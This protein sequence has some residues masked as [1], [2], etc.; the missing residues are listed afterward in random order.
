MWW[1]FVARHNTGSMSGSSLQNVL[2][3]SER[4][5]CLLRIIETMRRIRSPLKGLS[6]GRR[7]QPRIVR[8]PNFEQLDCASL[9]GLSGQGEQSSKYQVIVQAR[10]SIPIFH[11]PSLLPPPYHPL[12][13]PPHPTNEGPF[14]PHYAKH[15]LPLLCGGFSSAPTTS[16]PP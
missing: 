3:F 10:T 12:V 16:R 6:R 13:W 1:G 8:G 11:L 15:D 2:M 7:S 4:L 14:G 5:D 9:P